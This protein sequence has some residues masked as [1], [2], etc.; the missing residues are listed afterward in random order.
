MVSWYRRNKQTLFRCTGMGLEF[1]SG[2]W[3]QQEELPTC[4][5][6]VKRRQGKCEPASGWGKRPCD[7]ER[8]EG[9]N[10]QWHILPSLYL[11]D[12]PPRNSRFL[13]AA[14]KSR[15]K[16]TG[17]WRINS[18]I[19]WTN[20]TYLTPWDLVGCTQKCWG[21]WLIC[22]LLYY[23]WKVLAGEGSWGLE[24]RKCHLMCSRRA[25]KSQ[26]S[27]TSVF[28]KVMKQILL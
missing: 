9:R 16:K 18:G 25:R 12:Q 15:A 26:I 27:L 28:E 22:G 7:K 21:S 17:S 1:W 24:E 10:T 4:V 14:V 3:G 19:V 2:A 5:S 11:Q 23:S 20:W 6:A 8:R 13:R